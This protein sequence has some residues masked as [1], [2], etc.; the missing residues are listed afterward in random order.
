MEN[1]VVAYLA[2]STKNN[3]KSN[4][5]ITNFVFICRYFRYASSKLNPNKIEYKVKIVRRGKKE[6]SVTARKIAHTS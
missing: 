3:N 2:K 5:E 4:S 6:Q 1:S